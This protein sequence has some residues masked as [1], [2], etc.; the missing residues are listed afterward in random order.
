MTFGVHSLRGCN[1]AWGHGSDRQFAYLEEK[2]LE[3]PGCGG[4]QRVS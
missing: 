3:L 1:S 4:G 2:P